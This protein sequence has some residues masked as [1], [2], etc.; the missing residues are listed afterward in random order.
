LEQLGAAAFAS[1][2][3]SIVKAMQPESNPSVYARSSLW[4]AIA[5]AMNGNIAAAL[6]ARDRA[7]E[8]AGDARLTAALAAQP[9]KALEAPAAAL[10]CGLRIELFRGRALLDDQEIQLA[11]R[12]AAV[13]FTLS[14]APQRSIDPQRLASVIWPELDAGQ[15][16]A[17]LKVAVTRLRSRLGIPGLVRFTNGKYALHDDVRIDLAELTQALQAYE[18]DRDERTIH[19]FQHLLGSYRPPRLRDAEWFAPIESELVQCSHRLADHL[20]QP[21]ISRGDVRALQQIGNALLDADACDEEGCALVIRSYMMEGRIDLG[22]AE[23]DRFAER[24]YAEL[25]CE[26]SFTFESLAATAYA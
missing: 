13:L 9:A 12:E 5:H 7:G 25:G 18:R 26:P 8:F 10:S 1:E 20:A 24:L 16:H 3:A 14:A 4:L 2:A 11:Q 17:A 22:R 6:A 23:Y 15:S 21:A 19:D